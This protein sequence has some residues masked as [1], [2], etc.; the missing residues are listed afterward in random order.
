[1]RVVL[2]LIAAWLAF[3][4]V[5][6]IY[7]FSKISKVDAEPSGHRPAAGSGTTY[8]LVGSDSRQGLTK[9]QKKSLG[10]GSAA[11][12]RTDTILLLHVPAGGGPNLMLSIPRDSYVSIPGHGKSKI[13]AAY[14]WGGPKLLVK[15]VEHDTGVRIDDYI[16]VGFTGFVDVV[17]AVGGITVCPKQRI[18]DPKAGH[19]RMR[20]G[21]QQVDGQTALDYSRSR[22]F[23]NGDITRELHQR[24]VIAAVGHKAASWQTFL[25]PWRYWSVNMAAANSL[26]IGQNVGPIDLGRFAWAMAHSNGSDTKKCVV[27]FTTLGA[28]TPAGSAVLWNEAKA[29]AIFRHIRADDTSAIHCKA[30]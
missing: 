5:T 12:Q 24:E 11:G 17:N 9:A 19:L 15:T 2:I 30:Q 28:S 7:A 18:V 27:P 29:K 23:A 20:P 13:N 6:P 14:A 16:E 8:L 1:M 26:Q 10:T 21:C 22:A 4:I 25:F 3:M